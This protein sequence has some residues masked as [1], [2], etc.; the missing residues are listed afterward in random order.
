MGASVLRCLDQQ[1]A[2]VA[3]A[4][5]GDRPVVTP[6]SGLASG[7]DQ[8][9]V[10]GRMVGVPKPG[11]IPERSDQSQGDPTINPAKKMLMVRA[12]LAVSREAS[13]VG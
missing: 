2:G 5:L 8:T 11:Q 6:R 10:T 12:D 7:R 4:G 9:E 1:A 3:I 13:M